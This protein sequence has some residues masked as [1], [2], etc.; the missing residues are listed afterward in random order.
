[1]YTHTVT[2]EKQVNEIKSEFICIGELIINSGKQWN[3]EAC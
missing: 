2:P 3:H 1:M